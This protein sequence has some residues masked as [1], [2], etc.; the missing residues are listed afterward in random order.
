M[1]KKVVAVKTASENKTPT[2]LLN[3]GASWAM[4][5]TFDAIKKSID[6]A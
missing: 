3:A 4:A 1:K 5:F 6:G 2:S